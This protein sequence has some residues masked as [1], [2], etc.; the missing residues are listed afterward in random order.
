[1]LLVWLALTD[2]I[3][4]SILAN[5]DFVPLNC[6]STMFSVFDP[7]KGLSGCNTC[8][9]N[10]P[11][12]TSENCACLVGY[13]QLSC[14]T[15]PVCGDLQTLSSD[16]TF[17][18]LC[19]TTIEQKTIG[20][21]NLNVCKCPTGQI[22]RDRDEATGNPL[23]TGICMPCSVGYYPNLLGSECLACPDSSN[24]IASI[25][26]N[27]EYYCT[28]KTA[29]GYDPMPFHGKCLIGSTLNTAKIAYGL[30]GG[31]VTLNVHTLFILI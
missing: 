23:S 11:S 30:T 10:L 12:S 25:N 14:S 7:T 28:C 29:M 21:V 3:T 16:K 17:C 4:A 18:L 24:M 2:S 13:D 26:D 27:G 1:M 6:K 15:Q 31:L 22:Y 19:P 20:N 5:H 8:P 9:L